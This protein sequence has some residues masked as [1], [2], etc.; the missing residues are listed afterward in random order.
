MSS[1]L[2]AYNSLKSEFNKVSKDLQS[3]DDNLKKLT[4]GQSSSKRNLKRTALESD[5]NSYID[6][7][8]EE[9]AKRNKFISKAFSRV[10]GPNWQPKDPAGD[11]DDKEDLHHR[12][13]LLSQVVSAVKETKSR[14]EALEEQPPDEKSKARNRR[15]F[16]IILGTLQKF[17]S[18]ESQRKQT[19]ARRA[20]I[21]EKLDRQAE[22]ER[23]VIRK[24]KKEL[25]KKKRESQAHLRRIELKMERVQVHQDWEKSH[26]TLI[27]FIQTKTKP[28]LFYMPKEHTDESEKRWKQTKDKY[29]L[30]LAEKRAKVQKELSEIDEMYKKETELDDEMM[31]DRD[32]DNNKSMEMDSHENT[33][34]EA[35]RPME[36]TI[37]QVKVCNRRDEVT[38]RID[39]E[40]DETNIDLEISQK[41]SNKINKYNKKKINDD[42][43][44]KNSNENVKLTKDNDDNN[45]IDN[46]SE[47]SNRTKSDSSNNNHTNNNNNGNNNNDKTETNVDNKTDNQQNDA[48]KSSSEQLAEKEFEPI[49]DDDE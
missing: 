36:D 30:I 7:N 16:G 9:P 25:Y 8:S 13:V 43:E 28:H 3:V 23:D 41:N 45:R 6:S 48:D 11:N 14:N 12:P 32:D 31:D 49:Y 24:E 20:Q 34:C 18:E 40:K 42:D 22:K 4:G 46:E 2:D 10:H 5:G 35:I 29:R 19:T 26:K 39:N 27:N 15:M 33:N 38:D 21:E 44:I 1:I 37:D 47:K 17:Q